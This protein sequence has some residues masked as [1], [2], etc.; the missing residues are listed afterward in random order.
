MRKVTRARKDNVVSLGLQA[1]MVTLVS[2]NT[3]VTRLYKKQ[4]HVQHA[5]IIV[6]KCHAIYICIN[7]RLRTVLFIHKIS[8][9]FKS[10]Y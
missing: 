4:T 6:E 9:P 1:L 10:Y 3:P 7:L 8:L 5:I 2:V